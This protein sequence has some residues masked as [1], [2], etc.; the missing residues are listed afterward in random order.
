MRSEIEPNKNNRAMFL[1]SITMADNYAII[2]PADL[3]RS[4]RLPPLTRKKKKKFAALI[5]P[6]VCE[7]KVR[8]YCEMRNGKDRVTPGVHRCNAARTKNKIKKNIK[9]KLC[10]QTLQRRCRRGSGP[11]PSI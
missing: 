6:S 1:A 7:S 9:K 10:A 3:P 5:L 2:C 4:C 11:R 8:R